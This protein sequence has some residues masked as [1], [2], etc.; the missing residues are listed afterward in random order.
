MSGAREVSLR[1]VMRRSCAG[2]F[3]HAVDV[4]AR[5]SGLPESCLNLRDVRVGFLGLRFDLGGGD[6]NEVRT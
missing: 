4:Q 1:Q 5:A 2:H 6:P 3:R